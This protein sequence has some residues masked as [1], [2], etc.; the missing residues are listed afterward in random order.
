MRSWSSYFSKV[1]ADVERYEEYKRKD[2]LRKRETRKKQV[3][4]KSELGEKTTTM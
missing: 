2:C 4:S 3:L 1:K